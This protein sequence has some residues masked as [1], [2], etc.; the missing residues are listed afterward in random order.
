MC[1]VYRSALINST[2]HPLERVSLSTPGS[3]PPLEG[4]VSPLDC[5][6]STTNQHAKRAPSRDS[7]YA[8]SVASAGTFTSNQN[9][10]NTI[11]IFSSGGVET[12]ITTCKEHNRKVIHV[13]PTDGGT[14]T[15]SKNPPTLDIPNAEDYARYTQRSRSVG[16]EL[17]D[18]NQKRLPSNRSA[19][20]SPLSTLSRDELWNPHPEGQRYLDVPNSEYTQQK[21]S[22]SGYSNQRVL[23]SEYPHQKVPNSEYSQRN[24]SGSSSYS[25]GYTSPNSYDFSQNRTRASVSLPLHSNLPSMSHEQLGLEKPPFQ[26]TPP[27]P[28][29]QYASGPKSPKS[30]YNVPSYDWVLNR[31]QELRE[32]QSRYNNSNPGLSMSQPASPMPSNL[33]STA[34]SPHHLRPPLFS[35]SALSAQGARRHRSLPQPPPRSSSAV[36]MQRHASN[37]SQTRSSGYADDKV[38]DHNRNPRYAARGSPH[39]EMPGRYAQRSYDS[40]LAKEWRTKNNVPSSRSE[41][42]M[43][44]MNSNSNSTFDT[45]SATKRP[46]ETNNND[47][48]MADLEDAISMLTQWTDSKTD[49][50]PNFNNHNKSGGIPAVPSSLTYRSPTNRP[51]SASTPTTPTQGM[52]DID[53]HIEEPLNLDG[54]VKDRIQSKLKKKIKQYQRTYIGKTVSR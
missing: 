15:V 17:D 32:N 4:S 29:S 39:R 36:L 16:N 2:S 9:P 49:H 31:I 12:K 45:N 3:I 11:H 20:S 22:N 5:T 26:F 8:S 34:Q 46:L 50:P 14:A 21:I 52:D 30:G 54:L 38:L 18:L 10:R 6:T 1:V 7:G 19:P 28:S 47:D 33:Y 48:L 27:A 35:S 13:F 24:H 51:L 37:S 25:T 44:V 41:S 53:L 42:D 23:T 40:G 43:H